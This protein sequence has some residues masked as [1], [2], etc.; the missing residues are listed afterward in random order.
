MIQALCVE[1]PKPDDAVA[2]KH[3]KELRQT[4]VPT[5]VRRMSKELH[6]ISSRCLA[7]GALTQE[8]VQKV[9]RALKKGRGTR[10]STPQAMRQLI[11]EYRA[12]TEHLV[13]R[14][15][16]TESKIEPTSDDK[17]VSYRR[18]D[19]LSARDHALVE[20]RY[21]LICLMQGGRS[22]K[23]AVGELGFPYSERTVRN[24]LKRYRER[25]LEGLVDGRSTRT[26]RP[27]PKMTNDVQSIVL[28]V[29]LS[30][31]AAGPKAVWRMARKHCAERN[32]P[33]P[34]YDIVYRFLRGQP[35]YVKLLR[36]GKLPGWKGNTAYQEYGP[37]GWGIKSPGRSNTGAL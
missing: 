34:G 19:E 32:L 12:L 31:P 29:W 2:R 15:P 5:T 20:K 24:L 13:A 9:R 1:T 10:S 14:L 16:V 18:V 8:E 3:C 21:R 30:F 22:M 37:W 11:A 25:G 27:R 4:A 7:A 35:R 26:R 33:Q 36:E 17:Q 28:R 23:E 6:A